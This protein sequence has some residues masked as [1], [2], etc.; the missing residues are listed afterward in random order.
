M[1]M[2]YLASLAV[3]IFLISYQVFF[4]FIEPRLDARKFEDSLKE[5]GARELS[6]PTGEA[7]TVEEIPSHMGKVLVVIPEHTLLMLLGP[8]TIPPKIHPA[9]YSLDRSIRAPDPGEVDTLI[10]VSKEL[11]GTR[12]HKK[13][14]FIGSETKVVSAHI[15]NL[16]VYDWRSRTYVGRWTLNPGNFK[17]G[18][19]SDEEIDAMIAATSNSTLLKFIDSM[20]E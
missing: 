12:V 3:I 6:I 10:R 1:D 8:E 5:F 20:Q 18:N 17:P 4:R 15:V 16:D 11:R 14:K 13:R 19:M 9:W 7:M 2:I